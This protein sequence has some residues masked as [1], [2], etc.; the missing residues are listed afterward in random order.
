LARRILIVLE[1]LVEHTEASHS[2]QITVSIQWLLHTT[3]E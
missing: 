2:I 3:E 1:N